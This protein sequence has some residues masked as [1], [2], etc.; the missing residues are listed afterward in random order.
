M[1]ALDR[2]PGGAE[3]HQQ[4]LFACVGEVL[5]STAPAAGKRS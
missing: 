1:E 4:A 2:L 5:H 3:H